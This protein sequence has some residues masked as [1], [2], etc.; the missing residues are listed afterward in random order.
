MI[1]Q[2]ELVN[3]PARAADDKQTTENDNIIELKRV[4]ACQEDFKFVYELNPI[5]RRFVFY[6]TSPHNV[7]CQIKIAPKSNGFMNFRVPASPFKSKVRAH[8]NVCV[9]SIIKILPEVAWGEYEIEC[10]IQKAEGATGSEANGNGSGRKKNVQFHIRS[11]DV[12]S[13]YS[14]DIDDRNKVSDED[15]YSRI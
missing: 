4:I 5:V 6:N 9:L 11:L 10:N 1:E 3:E 7:I 2:G 8:S 15:F 14:K 12:S 13:G